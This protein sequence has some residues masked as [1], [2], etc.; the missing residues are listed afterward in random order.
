MKYICLDYAFD[1][2][3]L[4]SNLLLIS[5]FYWVK[6]CL[7]VMAFKA[8]PEPSP[9]HFP[10]IMFFLR[11]SLYTL[12]FPK[13]KLVS[14]MLFI[15]L[16]SFLLPG[17]PL[18]LFNV[19]PCTPIAPLSCSHLCGLVVPGDCEPLKN[20]DYIFLSCSSAEFSAMH[21]EGTQKVSV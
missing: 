20:E 12:P 5:V 13:H 18:P 2:I 10:T 21:A 14:H 3:S 1:L 17:M 11:A 9:A 4:F 15:L 8:F 6:P 16:R 19:I 7:L